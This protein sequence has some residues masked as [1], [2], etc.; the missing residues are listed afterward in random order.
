MNID[1]WF[2]MTC[3][4]TLKKGRINFLSRVNDHMKFIHTDVGSSQPTE[5]DIAEK[6]R[7]LYL[8]ACRKTRTIPCE[9]VYSNLTQETI[10]LKHRTLGSHSIKAVCIALVVSVEDHLFLINKTKWMN[11]TGDSTSDFFDALLATALLSS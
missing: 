11:F 6:V 10:S 7:S 2:S 9:T 8:E 1:L 4:S 5:E 3:K